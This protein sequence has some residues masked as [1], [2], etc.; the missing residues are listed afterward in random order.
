MRRGIGDVELAIRR[1]AHRVTRVVELAREREAAGAARHLR[2]SNALRDVAQSAGSGFSFAETPGNLRSTP[3]R[4]S[5]SSFERK[6]TMMRSRSGCTE[7]STSTGTPS[8]TK[9]LESRPVHMSSVWRV[10]DRSLNAAGLPSGVRQIQAEPPQREAMRVLAQPLDLGLLRLLPVAQ[11]RVLL[12]L[13]PHLDGHFSLREREALRIRKAVPGPL[14][15]GHQRHER[16]ILLRKGLQ[17]GD[18]RRERQVA[19]AHHEGRGLVDRGDR[20]VVAGDQRVPVD[21]R[22]DRKLRRYQSR[23]QANEY[24]AW[25]H[26]GEVCAEN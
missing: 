13:A 5:A 15:L 6:R 14:R 4:P 12:R 11:V 7:V 9:L 3:R 2:A 17:A 21:G 23:K 18:V 10:A 1:D 26:G 22:G 16:R 8:N 25:K 20:G 19:V 24:A